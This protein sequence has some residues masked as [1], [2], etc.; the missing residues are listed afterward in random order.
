MPKYPFP[1]RTTLLL[2]VSLLCADGFSQTSPS[3]SDK[4]TVTQPIEWFAIMSNIKV[5]KRMSVYVEG[6]FRYAGSLDPMQYQARTGLD[7]HINKQLS[8][9]PLAYVYVWNPIYGKQPATFVNNEHRIF[10][11]VSY[12][13]H[14]GP[15]F[16]SHRARLEQRFIQV[17][18]NNNGE[19][20]Y[21]GYD[22][23]L[24]RFRYRFLANVP[25]NH[26]AMDPK[27]IYACLYDEIFVDFGQSV[28]Y[29]DPDQNR[30]FAGMGYQVNKMVSIQGG[31]LYQMLIKLSGVKQENNV[32][33]QIQF[34][35]N[36]DAT[37]KEP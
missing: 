28:V 20:V 12:K 15:A 1:A 21:K 14:V 32:G 13:H 24:N 5:H 3:F 2:L 22:L 10:Q 34:Q 36:L 6:Q 29:T 35:Y 19:I 26:S 37:R 18:Q 31:F 23:Y 11:Q 17:H 9:M 33:F 25:I 30:F 4:E 8:I 16:I 27:T 7:I